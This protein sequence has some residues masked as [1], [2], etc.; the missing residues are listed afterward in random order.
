[1]LYALESPVYN[2]FLTAKA[3]AV[4]SVSGVDMSGHNKMMKNFDK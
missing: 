1:M 2:A 3:A 4:K